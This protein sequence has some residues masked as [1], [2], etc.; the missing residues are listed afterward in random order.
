[1]SNG[2][3]LPWH[4]R[5]NTDPATSHQAAREISPDVSR[6]TIWV[7]ECVAGHPNSTANELARFYGQNDTRRIGKRLDG[8]VKSGLVVRGEPR[9]CR[10]SGRICTTWNPSARHRNARTTRQ[11]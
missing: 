5:R 4:L 1:M 3:L 6:L 9:R 7:G 10:V 8:A 11:P 2:P